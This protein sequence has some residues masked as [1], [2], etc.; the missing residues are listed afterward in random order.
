[1]GYGDINL[2]GGGKWRTFVGLLYMLVAMCMAYSVFSTAASSALSIVQINGTGKNSSILFRPF[3]RN[4]DDVR[5]SLHE[6][7]RRIVIFRVA[8]LIVWF[9][10]LNLVGVFLARYFIVTSD[11][12]SQQWDWMTT[13]YWAVQTTT[14]IGE[15]FISMRPELHSLTLIAQQ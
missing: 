1:M 15:N 2:A 5:L 12:D 8:E 11:V 14:T 7:V 6:R 13:I 9:V 3:V 10:L 4:I